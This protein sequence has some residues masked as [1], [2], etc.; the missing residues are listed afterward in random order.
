MD[1]E[2]EKNCSSLNLNNMSLQDLYIHYLVEELENGTIY[3]SDMEKKYRYNLDIV[4]AER[5]LGTRRVVCK[6][7]DVL[8]NRFFVEEIVLSK[9]HLGEINEKHL[10]S[11]FYDFAAYYEFL[12]GEIYQNA[13][14]YKY[15]FSQ[16]EISNFSIDIN[17]IN[18]KSF[19]NY[20]VDDFVKDFLKQ[21]QHHNLK[22]EVKKF[23]DSIKSCFIVEQKWKDESGQ[24]IK[25]CCNTF[26]YFF[27]LVHFLKCDLSNI[28]LSE[29]DLV[30][31][32]TL[33][34]I[35]KYSELNFAN[36]KLNSNFLSKLD[37]KY[38]SDINNVVEFNSTI[39]ENKKDITSALA[40]E[41]ETLDFIETLKCQTVYY[42]SDL[43]LLHRIY[44]AKCK[45]FKSIQKIIQEII[46]TLLD[47]IRLGDEGSYFIGGYSYTVLI[48]GDTS[49]DFSLFKYFVNTLKKSIDVSNLDVKVIFTLGNHEFWDFEGRAVDEIIDMYKKVINDNDMYLLQNNI[50]FID[51]KARY[52]IEEISTEELRTLS[53]D[54][55]RNR[56]TRARLMLFGGLGFAGYNEEFNAN[57][58]IYRNAINRNQEIEESKKFE[59][60]YEK[61]C[62]CLSERRV[63]VFTHMP[64]KDWCSHNELHKGFVYVNGHTHR[65]LFYDDGDY[66]IYADNQ[67]GYHREN[68]RL[69]YFYLED[70][71]D[72]FEDYQD[73]IYEITREEYIDFYR[74]KNI[75]MDFNREGYNI[76]MLKKF[77]YYCFIAKSN[78]GYLLILNGGNLKRLEHK[79][80]NYYFENMDK[81]IAYIKTPLDEFTDY[82]KQIANEVKSIGGSGTIHG[83]IIDI[84]F[85]NHIFINPIDLK[86]TAYWASDIVNKKIFDNTPT[87]LQN[88]CPT[89]YANYLKLIENNKEKAI[90]SKKSEI[91]KTPQIYLDTEIY[92]ASREIKK[93]QKLSSNI[94]SIWIEPKVKKLSN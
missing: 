41:K 25:K 66:R 31:Y 10:I 4:K 57:K 47:N 40:S 69:K 75:A 50:L 26:K 29:A 59:E 52:N 61:V 22:Y 71:Y 60:L 36:A 90:I 38:Q 51:D 72:I 48:G 5:Q 33:Q 11:F 63:V 2:N 67:V 76:F 73:G 18:F 45:N 53:K 89:I 86:A 1:K 55:L 79:D 43:H 78:K 6:G 92:S 68:C 14:Y 3:Y 35:V 21:F 42:I 65:N 49:S 37:Q 27:D 9:N 30:F 46:Y 24:A 23:Y 64:Q 15:N 91:V 54:K 28:D 62:E 70:D 13:C 85:F 20:D 88:N 81:V 44:N 56:L 34:D 12:Q 93:M 19:I 94:L 16:Y 77:G 74:G 80:I 87:L 83:A 8:F 17:K 84:D 39:S 82:Q 58:F 7:Y 32:E